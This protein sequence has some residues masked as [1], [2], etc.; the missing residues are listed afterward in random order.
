MFYIHIRI[1]R[2]VQVHTPATINVIINTNKGRNP[3]LVMTEFPFN[4]THP[5]IGNKRNG[6][7]CKI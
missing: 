4:N 5:R 7:K 3:H 2:W 6:Q 1:S